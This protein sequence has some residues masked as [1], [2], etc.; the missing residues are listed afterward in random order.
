MRSEDVLDFKDKLFFRK[1]LIMKGK[2]KVI[3]K[4]LGY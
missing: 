1:F 2:E 4:D 3:E